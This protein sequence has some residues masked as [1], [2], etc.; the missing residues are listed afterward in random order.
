MSCNAF[1]GNHSTDICDHR[2]FDSKKR[3]I[4]FMRWEWY[5]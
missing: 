5:C 1:V 3:E 2:F 4:G